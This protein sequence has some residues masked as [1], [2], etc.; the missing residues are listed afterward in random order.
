MGASYCY[1]EG[2]I[3]VDLTTPNQEHW[4]DIYQEYREL[5]LRFYLLGDPKPEL[6]SVT[7]QV[8]DDIETL[9]V[10]TH[11]GGEKIRIGTG[12]GIGTSGFLADW[13]GWPGMVTYSH[14]EAGEGAVVHSYGY[15]AN[16]GV[17]IT[18]IDGGIGNDAGW[19][20][21]YPG[22]SFDNVI[23]SWTYVN[24][25]KIEWTWDVDGWVHSVKVGQSMWYAS[26]QRGLVML[27]V[28]QVRDTYLRYRRNKGGKGDSGSPLF[29][30]YSYG[31]YAFYYVHGV[32]THP[33][34]WWDPNGRGYGTRIGQVA[35][36]LDVTC[37]G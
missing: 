1:L 30:V 20:V 19:Y 25:N 2:R 10:T 24:G 12:G 21:I 36:L 15:G 23:Y 9:S 29:Y 32:H 4:K 16:V 35:V 13:S 28:D 26:G 18:M 31:S 34:P 37:P 22:V 14:A 17:T 6:L 8:A 11:G 27:T 5:P 7:D 33:G 3:T